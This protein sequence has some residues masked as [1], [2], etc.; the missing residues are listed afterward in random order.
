M[1]GSDVPAKPTTP[2]DSKLGG[3]RSDLSVE[4]ATSEECWSASGLGLGMLMLDRPWRRAKGPRLS[5]GVLQLTD[6]GRFSIP[7][8]PY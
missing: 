1:A 7:W 2:D 8:L 3:T 4:L 5:D 6:R